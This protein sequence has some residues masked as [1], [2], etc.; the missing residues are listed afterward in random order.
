MQRQLRI[1]MALMAVGLC[2]RAAQLAVNFDHYVAG[3]DVNDQPAGGLYWSTVTL[4]PTEMSTPPSA[5]RVLEDSTGAVS[6]VEVRSVHYIRLA[7]SGTTVSA[8]FVLDGVR[9]PAGVASYGY[10]GIDNNAN[11]ALNQWEFRVP[12]AS[13]LGNWAF[14]LF[15]GDNRNGGLS[16][17][18]ANI[19]G[20]FSFTS[21][22]GA[23]TGGVTTVFDGPA[24][25]PN[26]AGMNWF[27]S[28]R[29]SGILPGI[30]NL[31][32]VDYYVGVLQFADL[33]RLTATVDYGSLHALVLTANPIP[34]PV[35][36]ALLLLAAGALGIRRPERP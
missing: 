20:T 30:Q 34:E 4:T 23:F 7:S 9:L 28:G 21:G 25:D 32:G 12:V 1:V 10:G 8:P 33:G 6:P 31:G 19:G 14:Q 35:A 15:A 18:A 29:L 5:W 2:A 36:F 24:T 16:P 3:T 27:R 17:V 26:G 22:V 13:G 11:E